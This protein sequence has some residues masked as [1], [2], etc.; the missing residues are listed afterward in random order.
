MIRRSDLMDNHLAV[1]CSYTFISASRLLGIN[2]PLTPP[3]EGLRMTFDDAI[4]T[5]NVVVDSMIQVIDGT[6]PSG[7]G[8]EPGRYGLLPLLAREAMKRAK[9]EGGFISALLR[10]ATDDDKG[11]R[12]L[13]TVD[14]N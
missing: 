14:C 11:H 9:A 6:S 1:I 12:E 8:G 2:C 10:Q 5:S 13:F 7:S 3:Q 4:L